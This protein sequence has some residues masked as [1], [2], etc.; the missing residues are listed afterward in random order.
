MNFNNVDRFDK[1]FKVGKL[2]DNIKLTDDNPCQQCDVNKTFEEMINSDIIAHYGEDIDKEKELD[3]YC[4]K[5]PR[6]E[7]WI[8]HCLKKLEEYEN[9][10]I[11][12]QKLELI[13]K[14]FNLKNKI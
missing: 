13:V 8:N 3:K 10:N 11:S 14:N 4:Q 9:I 1:V 6:R 12:T 2:F 5:C 7:G